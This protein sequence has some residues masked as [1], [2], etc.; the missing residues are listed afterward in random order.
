MEAKSKGSIIIED[1]VWL[2]YGC[3]ILSGVKISKGSVIGS[4]A[5]VAKDIPP[6]SI[7]VGN[8]GQVIKKRFSDDKIT[9]LLKIDLLEYFDKNKNNLDLLYQKI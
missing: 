6:Y 9:E 1:D 7:V 4:G 2:G 5:V 3:M 8:P